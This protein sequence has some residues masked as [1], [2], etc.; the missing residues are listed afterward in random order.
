[1]SVEAHK[2]S[3]ALGDALP[4]R[5]RRIVYTLQ[6][7][8]MHQSKLRQ[9]I[10]VDCVHRSRGTQLPENSAERPRWNKPPGACSNTIAGCELLRYDR[11]PSSLL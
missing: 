9:A 11:T 8:R 1:V 4:L 6:V 2:A 7:T 10:K 3:P 5:C